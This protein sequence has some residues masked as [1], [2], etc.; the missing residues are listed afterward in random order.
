MTTDS[1]FRI[2]TPLLVEELAR[3]R[4]QVLVAQ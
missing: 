2:F 3:Y 4:I 1:L